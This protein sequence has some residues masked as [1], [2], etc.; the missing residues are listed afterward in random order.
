M[1]HLYRTVWNE[2]TNTFVAVA[3]NVKRR[4]KRSGSVCTGSGE[5]ASPSTAADGVGWADAGSPTPRA[6]GERWAL[7][8]SPAYELRGSRGDASET[9]R[10]QRRLVTHRPGLMRLEPRLVFDG[11]AVDTALEV[12]DSPTQAE[13]SHPAVTLD[14]SVDAT[15][16][17]A[18]VQVTRGGP[19][20]ERRSA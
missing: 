6:I 10:P 12:F 1:N 11:A 7:F 18:Q 14:A 16:P 13:T 8:P 17:A 5:A 15:P 19:G 20:S 3:E 9:A 2:I 4:G